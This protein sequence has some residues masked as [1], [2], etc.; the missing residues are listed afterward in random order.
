[1]ADP[2]TPNMSLTLP[3]V[4]GTL[5]PD[6]ALEL[7][8]DL[9]ILD[10][11]D[12]SPGRGTAISPQGMSINEDLDFLSNNAIGLRSARF[13]P[14]GAPLA[15]STDKGCLYESGVDLFYNDGNGV[16]IRITQAGSIVGTS[17]SIGGLVSPASATYVSATPAFVFQSNANT[18]AN[19]DGG[20]ITIREIV[21]NSKGITL[22][23]PAGLANDYTITFPGSL[24]A[25]TLPLSLSS[26][27]N[28]SAG[29]ITGA[30]IVND[31]ALAGNVTI[32]GSLGVGT[33][34]NV[35]TD[36]TTLGIVDVGTSLHA[37][38]QIV[39]DTF[40]YPTT[41][42]LAAFVSRRNSTVD[43]A[44]SSTSFPIVTSVNP[45][46]TGLFVLRGIITSA[47][48]I[49]NGEGFTIT[50]PST[51]IYDITLTASFLDVPAM[52]AT[53]NI[54]PGVS[55]AY[56]AN[57]NFT[58]GSGAAGSVIRV[59]TNIQAGGSTIATNVAFSIVFIGQRLA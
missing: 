48:A 33:S 13:A 35:G 32:T 18:A 47:G 1:M 50:H 7:N 5:S 10:D 15:L 34:L 9:G 38:G 16:Q 55:N 19:L 53:C 43:I 49:I 22:S 54:V 29:K 59:S 27:G 3:V 6:W 57:C 41:I 44:S 14:Q 11:H 2:I 40:I 8:S 26:S 20:S 30:Q 28:L 51:G 39:S 45:A 25:S 4:G 21:A 58:S 12:H 37:N 31:A 56:I 24:P 23:A 52:I 36:L 17:G 46:T 42:A